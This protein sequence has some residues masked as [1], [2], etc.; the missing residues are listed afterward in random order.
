MIENE[1]C[2][3]STAFSFLFIVKGAFKV[4]ILWYL[5]LQLPMQLEPIT[6]NVVSSNP[7]HGQV[8]SIQYHVIKFVSDLGQVVG[9]LLVLRFP[10]PIKLT[11]AK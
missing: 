2:F 4:V 7:A 3:A 11:A 8:N 1:C 9:F 10:L 6:T 5:D